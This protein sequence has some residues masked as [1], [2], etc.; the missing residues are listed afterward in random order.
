MLPR[1]HIAAMVPPDFAK[2]AATA[3]S[4]VDLRTPTGPKEAVRVMVKNPSHPMPFLPTTLTELRFWAAP[5]EGGGAD[6]YVEADARDADSADLA[7][8]EIRQLVQQQNSIGVRLVTRGLLNDFEVRSDGA[9]VKGHLL[10]SQEQLE[11]LYDLVASFLGVD[12]E[13]TAPPPK[14]TGAPSP[15]HPPPRRAPP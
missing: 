1:P 7:A 10:V 8:R 11:A 6:A 14:G 2:V 13:G 15:S 12:T 5:R 4:R 3:F 9:M